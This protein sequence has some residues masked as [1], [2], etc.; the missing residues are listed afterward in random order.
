MAP[1][2]A[3]SVFLSPLLSFPLLSSPLLS[4]PLLSSSS[5]PGYF[6]RPYAAWTRL[7]LSWTHGPARIIPR[8]N[9]AGP[10]WRCRL[11][12]TGGW[13]RAAEA[14]LVAAAVAALVTAAAVAAAAVAEAATA[15]FDDTFMAKKTAMSGSRRKR[16]LD[17]GLVAWLGTTQF[18]IANSAS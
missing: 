14:A 17:L 13:L 7:R 10:G 12:L 15:G 6:E 11:L 8:S 3:I 1:H 18:G 2:Y 4:F 5:F 9:I 16:E